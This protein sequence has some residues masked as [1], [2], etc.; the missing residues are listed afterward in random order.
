MQACLPPR[1]LVVGQRRRCVP[2]P[3]VDQRR[4]VWRCRTHAPW[5][6]ALP[7]A[8]CPVPRQLSCCFFVCPCCCCRQNKSVDKPEESTEID[9]NEPVAL[10]FALRYLNSFA[11]VR[12]HA[13]SS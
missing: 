10:T 6:S 7:A 9:I 8:A 2:A 11:K 1:L 4:Q 3:Q 5:S 13:S 12:T